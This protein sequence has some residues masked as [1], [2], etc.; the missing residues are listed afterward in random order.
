MFAIRCGLLLAALFLL[1]GC[2]GDAPK[3]VEVKGKVTLDGAP[4]AKGQVMFDAGDGTAPATLEVSGGT[5]AG[6][7]PAGKKTVRI[8]SFQKV[9][10]KGTGPGAEE[11]SLQEIVLPRYNTESKETVEVKDPGPNEFE[12]KVASK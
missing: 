1:A 6:K 11:E 10:Q 2:S 5:F 3:T 12:F 4:M 8:S 7:V 9:A